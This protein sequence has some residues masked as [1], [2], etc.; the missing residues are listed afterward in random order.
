MKH[1]A[2]LIAVF[3]LV[4]PVPSF[5][6][7]LT[8]T[9][10]VIYFG[11][12]SIYQ[13][14]ITREL[15][16]ENT[17]DG[18][19]QISALEIHGQ[20]AAQFAVVSGS[21]SDPIPPGSS[22]LFQV[23]A[24]PTPTPTPYIEAHIDVIVNGSEVRVP[25]YATA[26]EPGA[27]YVS[28]SGNDDNPGTRA[29]PLQTIQ[30]AV[31]QAVPHDFIFAED[32]VYEGPVIMTRSGEPGAYITLKSINKWG[33]KIEV[34]DGEG[35]QDGI[36]VVANYITID[37]FELYDPAP[38]AGRIGN[39]ITIYESHHVEAVNNNIHDFG[40]SG[41]QGAYC[42]HVLIE[43]NT[44]YNNAKYNPTQSS[45][46][47]I[48]RAWAVDDAPGYHIVIRNNRSFGNTTITKNARNV[49]TDG[50]GIIIDDLW[51]SKDGERYPHRTLIENNLA[52][53][54]GGSG[55][56]IYKSSHIDVFNNTS[57]HNRH[58]EGVTG[59]FRGEL[60]SNR[61]KDTVWRNNIGYA[62]PG[63][64]ITEYNRAIFAHKAEDAVY[65]NNIT[66][67]TDSNYTQSI[68]LLDSE[69]T[70]AYLM[71]NNLIGVNPHFTDASNL[72]FSLK[73]ESPAID[74]GSDDIASLVD[75]NY[76]TRTLGPVDIGAFEYFDV[77]YRV[78][79]TSFEALVAGQDIQLRWTTASEL[80]N[81][82]FAVEQRTPESD[83][84]EVMFVEGHGTS[85]VEQV[86][87]TTL[88]NVPPG[89]HF[90]RLKKTGL[91]GSFDYSGTVEVTV[92]DNLPVELTSFEA[93]VAG[94]DVQLRWITA[95]ELN[96]AG[97]DVE[98][99]AAE[100]E[101]QKV[102]FVEGHG[103]TH[104]E[105]VYETTLQDVSPGTYALRL[106]QVDFD[107]A[108]AYSEVIDITVGATA[109]HL[110]QSYPNPFN[111]QATIRY[112]LPVSS[113]VTLEVF[114]L[115]GR[116]V[117]VLVHEEQA[118]GAYSVRFDGQNVSTGTYVYR[119]TAGA[120]SETKTMVLLR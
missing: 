97:F 88:Q 45:G 119:L 5:A 77:P 27:F 73:S 99:R 69:P 58:N 2:R 34:I 31:D 109:Y 74:A 71:A 96:N 39:G 4:V 8:A 36:K 1:S 28:P 32:G 75:I 98:L 108:F 91:D 10:E 30:R 19:L 120:F 104:T 81:A 82:G 110:A 13:S 84:E 113:L 94:N 35:A 76:L 117:R 6:Q 62:N 38:G 53:D 48:W 92:E 63:S 111:P 85:D 33:A 105:Q 49:N 26:R 7:D 20:D 46:I 93:L 15:R 43:N 54:N 11:D 103:T 116:S 64:G 95:S 80:N 78:E 59:T 42:D 65:E 12:M 3:L 50:S 90:L 102:S 44:V 112:T 60:Y 55:V 68:T 37:G 18:P 66:Y 87:Q 70:E 56:H 118:A 106:K 86:Y 29:L 107:G 115:L 25:L 61:S 17:S 79:L 16:L 21:I 9:P 57:Y 51:E 72:D 114:D 47:S 67:S 22:A 52:Y 40:G 101:F 23:R 100:M 14:G 83:F 24:T 89:T 41:I